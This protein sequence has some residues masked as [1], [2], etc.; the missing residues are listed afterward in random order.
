LPPI[1]F[2][3]SLESTAQGDFPGTAVGDFVE[4]SDARALALR[5]ALFELDG[6]INVDL[7]EVFGNAPAALH[8]YVAAT[9]VGLGY[10]EFRTANGT[11]DGD[12]A[13]AHSLLGDGAR[14]T[15]EDMRV[16]L[17]E[18]G[19]TMGLK[20]PGDYD[21]GG[22]ATPGPYLPVAEDSTRYT[23][24]SYSHDATLGEVSMLGLYDIAALQALFGADMAHAAGN[25][26]YYR[27]E[28]GALQTIWDAG[29]RDAFSA[30][31]A[32]ESTRIDLRAGAFSDMGN[33]NHL[34]IAYGVRIEQAFGGDYADKIIGNGGANLLTGGAGNDSISGGAA[35]DQL[36]GQGDNDRLIGG[37]GEDKIFG[38]TGNDRL[39]GG[40]GNDRFTEDEGNDFVY[41]GTGDDRV[42]YSGLAEDF[43]VTERTDG[44]WKVAGATGID[45]LFGIELLVFDDGGVFL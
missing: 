42:T 40:T 12:A 5:T 4:W 22:I 15:P 35:R 37:S 21:G 38:G 32:V 44:G 31:D 24:M 26:T 39:Y 18:I 23:L 29:G 6:I 20:H 16:L 30:E 19:H 17:H 14:L 25:N 8:Y 2:Y 27:P 9:G 34:A 45:K 33:G 11:W 13:F 1:T 3:Y 10:G 41:G 43:V 7:A 36:R 28:R